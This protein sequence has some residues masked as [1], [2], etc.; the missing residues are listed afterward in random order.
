ML[1]LFSNNGEDEVLQKNLPP[2]E[3][4]AQIAVKY[5]HQCFAKRALQF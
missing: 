3:S 5:C 1:V 4:N 2:V